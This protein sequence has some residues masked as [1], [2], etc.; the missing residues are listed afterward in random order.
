MIVIGTEVD[1]TATAIA[2]T[3]TETATEVVEI[4]K[5]RGVEIGENRH[6]DHTLPLPTLAQSLL[7]ETRNA[8]L[9]VGVIDQR[10]EMLRSRQYMHLLRK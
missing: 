6:L 10:T 2:E 9:E 4:E 3:D 1:V 5:D 8:D 7:K